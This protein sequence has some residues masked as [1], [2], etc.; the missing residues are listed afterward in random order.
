MSLDPSQTDRLPEPIRSAMLLAAGLGTR[1]RPTT[2]T[3]PKPLVPVG[4]IALIDRVMAAARAEG[5]V[6]F[7]IN[8]HHLA[9]QVVAHFAG[10]PDVTVLRETNL[11]GTGGGVRNALT[12]LPDGP[13]LVMNTDSFWP[14]DRDRPLGRLQDQFR[15]GGCDFAL[16]CVHPMRA[17]GFARSH[18][19]CLDP[20]GRVTADSGLPVIYGGVALVSRGLFADAPEDPFSLYRLLEPALAA[21]R[22]SGTLLGAEWYHVGDPAGRDAVEKALA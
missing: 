9:D 4:G 10:H 19:F 17:T 11:L 22:V 5:I 13:I 14:P 20:H 15:R 1:L 2:E 21:D 8:A 3:Q 6:E 7:A 18:D 16:L 12:V